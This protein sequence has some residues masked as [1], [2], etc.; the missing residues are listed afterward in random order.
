MSLTAGV[1]RNKIGRL[2]GKDRCRATQ[3]H[4]SLHRDLRPSESRK[5][6]NKLT[7][8][9]VQPSASRG[10]DGNPIS[11]YIYFIYR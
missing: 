1:W 9:E 7:I 4:N 2:R 10:T 8:Y 6:L 5:F 3:D 11:L